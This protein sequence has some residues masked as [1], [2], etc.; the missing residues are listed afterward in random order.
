[1]CLNCDLAF[2][3]ELTRSF[4]QERFG[5]VETHLQVGLPSSVDDLG[6]D[7]IGDGKRVSPTTLLVLTT[8][9]VPDTIQTDKVLMVGA[10]STISTIDRIG[11]QDFYKV[12]LEAGKTYEI[13]NYAYVGGPGGAPLADAYVELFDAAGNMIVSADGGAATDYNQANSGFDVLLV[14]TPKA[15]GTYYVNSRSF[16]N[17]A[18]DGSTTG[19]FVGDYELFLREQVPDPNAYRPYYDVDSPLYALDWGTQVNRVNQSARN[20]DGDEGNRATGNAQ[21]TPDI[22]N[23]AHAVPG[24]NVISIYF[25]KAGDVFTSLEDPTNPGLPPVLVSAGTQ[26]WEREVVFTSLREFEKVADIVYVEVATREEADFFFTTYAGTPGPGVSLLGSMAPPDYPNEGLAQF[27]S[28][29]YRWTEENLQQGGFSYVTLIHEFGHG[30]G[31]AHPHDNGGRSGVMRGVESDGPVADYTLGDFDLNQ[32]IHTMMSY[33]DGW[34]MSPHGNAP[35]DAGYGYLGG[36][37][38]FDIAAIQDKYGVNEEWATGSDVYVLKDVNAPGTFYTSIWDAGGTDSIVYNG[39][40][41]SVIDLRAATLQYEFGGGG[42]VSYADGIFGGFTIANGVSIENARSG[43]G[44]DTLVG[45]DLANIL[46]GGQGSDRLEGGRGD[47]IFGVSGFGDT[48]VEAAGQGFD[49]VYASGSFAL[50][51]GQ[52]VE[53]LSTADWASNAAIDLFGNEA[54]NRLLGNAGANVLSGGGGADYLA[55]FGGNDAYYVDNR[56]D[57]VDEAPNGGFD[58]VYASS[59]FD[60]TSGSSVEIMSTSDQSATSAMTLRGSN[61]AQTIYG[62]AGAN[63]LDGRGG[64]DLLIGL[65][66][67]DSYGIDN[68]GDMILEQAGQGFD[69]AYASASYAL[70]SAVSVEVLSTGDW[71]SAMAINLT[72]NEQGNRL[73]GNAGANVL[74]GKGGADALTGFAGADTFAFTTAL[75]GGNVDQIIGWDDSDRIALDDA[76]FTA[77][78]GAGLGASAFKVG[79]AATDGDDRI[80]YNAQTGALLYDADGSGSAAAIQFAQ[81][82]TNLSTLTASDFVII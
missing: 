6:P 34:P 7:G 2:R 77:L 5:N 68:A 25:A 75:G 53:V 30:H 42:R 49:T 44:D 15:S 73:F 55:G 28:G 62:N 65:A 82:S 48:V 78:S 61:Q 43:S 3:S 64:A 11:D 24:K 38:A 81:L 60:L 72:G 47:D 12:T 4:Y 71:A 67:D 76:V 33:Q 69:T 36:L 51:A 80:I 14:Y 70:A 39:A 41:N 57:V 23:P 58:I 9:D 63:M 52:E 20:P 13:G 26:A 46:D 8:D 79:T 56:G 35:T 22:A 19:E 74:D 21:G 17:A 50:G 54:N 10:P 16:D 1:M 29:D 32:A 66:G 40:R 27:N 31:L 37:M 18:E 45:N 59:D